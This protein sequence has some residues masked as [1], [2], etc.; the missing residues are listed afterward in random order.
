MGASKSE[1]FIPDLKG[2]S[3][4]RCPQAQL[5]D[6]DYFVRCSGAGAG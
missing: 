3:L 4:V 6:H 5:E 1:I 2:L